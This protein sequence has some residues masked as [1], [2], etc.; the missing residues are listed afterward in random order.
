MPLHMLKIYWRSLTCLARTA[1]HGLG[2]YPRE[3]TLCGHRGRFLG[4][5]DPYLH[6]V[7]CPRCGTLGHHRLLALANR[8]YDFFHG[9]DILH[10]APEPAIGQ[11]V[12]D[13]SPRSYITAGHAEGVDCREDIEALTIRDGCFDVVICLRVLEHVDDRK[14]AHE[15]FRVLRPGGMLLAMAPVVEGWDETYEEAGRRADAWAP[16]PRRR[17]HARFF[18]RDLRQRLAE[19]G[20]IVDEYT[21]VEPQ[22]SRYGL[23][24]GEKVFI[25]SRPS[26]RHHDATG[27]GTTAGAAIGGVPLPAMLHAPLG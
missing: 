21:A 4:Y 15:L 16:H 3:C 17:G 2:R 13:S 12:L 25:C 7:L 6:D 5:G 1:W 26:M 10:F 14:A 23:M 11:L 27:Q 24:R 9:R 18:G 22:V 8:D 19:P 20:F